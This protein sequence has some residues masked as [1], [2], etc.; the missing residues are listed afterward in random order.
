MTREQFL[1][2]V[3]HPEH[4]V[5]AP[6][7]QIA[8]LANQFPYCQPLR[9]LYLKQLAGTDSV[10]YPQQLKITAALAPD[11]TRLFR[12][13]H[14]EPDGPTSEDV[15]AGVY[16]SAD[17]TAV[18]SAYEEPIPVFEQAK[19]VTTAIVPEY[20]AP[21]DEAKMSVEEIV[22]QRLKELNLW[23]EPE[24]TATPLEVTYTDEETS[25][26]EVTADDQ[27]NV[28]NPVTE[29]TVTDDAL[30]ED[31]VSYLVPDEEEYTPPV[32]TERERE[33]E[34]ETVAET[35][36]ETRPAPIAETDPLDEIIRESIVETRIRNADYFDE[37][38]AALLNE[39]PEA[40]APQKQEENTSAESITAETDTEPYTSHTAEIHSFTDWLKLNHSHAPEATTEAAPAPEIP[41]APEPAM[42]SNPAIAVVAEN[43]P[44]A[45]IPVQN[46]TGLTA[47]I[48]ENKSA[49]ASSSVS[50][51]VG[52]VAQVKF[53]FVKSGVETSAPVETTATVP[54]AP[55]APPP[56]TAFTPPVVL[57]PTTEQQPE[58]DITP[59]AATFPPAAEV[60][61]TEEVIPPRRPI[62]DPSLVDTDPPKPRVPA[63]DLIDKF[64]REEPRISPSKSTFYSPSNMAKKSILE[65]DDLVTET[66]ANIYAQQGN[67]KK[68]I[69]FYQKLSLKFP[70]KSRYFA[71]LIEELKKKSNI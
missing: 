52:S 26:Q 17:T 15:M 69:S 3:R 9:Y 49:P 35:E 64:I 42:V 66:L 61:F 45:E 22:N 47:G 28:E 53:I 38:A 24:E 55:V 50:P 13:I 36:T 48:S 57:P 7:E 12:L 62:P 39:L 5:S 4:V 19:D 32:D 51:T 34:R 18:A 70:E 20:E 58:P 65:P 29:T 14:P 60:I 44:Q 10:Q 11:R 46:T 6:A 68:A 71:A 67:F 56:V 43:A 21:A 59:M 40:T 27:T 41:Q 31:E 30:V 16:E 2:F 63:G 37:K 8:A 25:T 1:D 23:Q 33:R 54:T